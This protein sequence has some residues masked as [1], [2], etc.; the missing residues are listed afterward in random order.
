MDI[1]PT[2]ILL[3]TDGSET[4]LRA[5]R[6]AGELAGKLGSEL[7]VVY[8]GPDIPPAFASMELQPARVEQESRKALDELVGRIEAEGGTV[9]EAH[10]RLGEAAEWIV[11]LGE[12]LGAGLI[13]VGS[14]GLGALKRAVM[15]SVSESVVRHA[16]CPVMVVRKDEESEER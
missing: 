13:V 5:A 16:H 7:H 14:R 15:G 11:T 12:E 1:F 6:V 3:G 8:V 9:A 4:A 10:L 2:K